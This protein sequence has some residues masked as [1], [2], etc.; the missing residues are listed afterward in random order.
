[1][2][3][4]SIVL[5]GC[6][7][8]ATLAPT[9][10]RAAD[11]PVGGEIILNPS[12]GRFNGPLGYG[13]GENNPIGIFA[14]P[15]ATVNLTYWSVKRR[16]GKCPQRGDSKDQFPS[17]AKRLSGAP[18]GAATAPLQKYTFDLGPLSVSKRYCFYVE[19]IESTELTVAEKKQLD[20]A[21]EHGAKYAS[22]PKD[23]TTQDDCKQKF[24]Y[25][26]VVARFEE[27]LTWTAGELQVQ[28][29]GGPA[30][31]TAAL[32]QMI[33]GDEGTRDAIDDIALAQANVLAQK[34][35]F[36]AEVAKLAELGGAGGPRVVYD[37]L[38]GVDPTN[39]ARA[40]KDKKLR[41]TLED[42]P[43]MDRSELL[44]FVWNNA[45][46]IRRSLRPGLP[47]PAEDA[48]RAVLKAAEQGKAKPGRIVLTKA[49][50]DALVAKLGEASTADRK[51]AI[52]AFRAKGLADAL[53]GDRPNFDAAGK[54]KPLVDV[55]KQLN[56]LTA[57][58]VGMEG[59]AKQVAD[60]LAAPAWLQLKERTKRFQRTNEVAAD[61]VYEPSYK[62]RFSSFVTAEFGVA[63][64]FFAQRRNPRVRVDFI[65]FFGVNF[66]AQPLDI[67]R[68]LEG[69]DV[70][71]RLSLTLGINMT[72]PVRQSE[73]GIKGAVGSQL[74]L[75]GAGFRVT[76]FLR[77]SAGSAFYSQENPNPLVD[78]PSTKAAL[79]LGLSL[80]INVI[81][82]IR[83]WYG[84]AQGRG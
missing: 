81:D 66:Y 42:D 3:G 31:L 19:V 25:A 51:A 15:G 30:K 10:S 21:L 82:T 4:K 53:P 63:P 58:V 38:P 6:L 32:G 8:L 14:K 78:D 40:I 5:C 35:A 57:V 52:Q 28:T 48:L 49:E 33:E 77:L 43:S 36:A 64:I 50:L 26:D 29:P 54:H 9:T 37:P 65:T 13:P 45:A 24:S 80:D 59:A 47:K 67:N 55:R 23:A 46:A 16:G 74:G 7:L 12:N 79:Y 11:K 1:M 84:Q 39:L 41:K 2:A 75:I 70:W 72:P 27:R 44:D 71:R 62:R 73:L 18:E 69:F 83:K 34:I 17:D 56:R 20:A 61:Y 22:C 76:E 68:P 60:A